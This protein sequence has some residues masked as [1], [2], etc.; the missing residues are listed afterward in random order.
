MDE[1]IFTSSEAIDAV[2]FWDR[3]VEVIGY[4]KKVIPRRIAGSTEFLKFILSNG[5]G[6]H[7]QCCIWGAND[8][9][10]LEAHINLNEILHID[11]AWARVP[12]KAEFNKGN[13]QFELQLFANTVVVSFGQHLAA[14]DQEEEEEVVDVD[15]ENLVHCEPGSRIKVI[16]YL[17][18]VF[19][20]Q[21]LGYGP[22]VGTF[23]CGSLTDGTYKLELRIPSLRAPRDF[24][25]GQKLSIIG[26]IEF[27]GPRMHLQISNVN[28]IEELDGLMRLSQLLEGFRELKRQLSDAE[29]PS[30]SRRRS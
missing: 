9:N 15:F 17:R 4:V 30:G 18:T 23:G 22:Q 28:D 2:Q 24:T 27:Q 25:K 7:I 1:N 19:V 14:V 8:I 3:T 13:C 12:S 5:S 11:G 29:V 16:G 20:E 26:T 10:A 6:K 21:R